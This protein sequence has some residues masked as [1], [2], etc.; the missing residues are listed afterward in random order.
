MCIVLNS[1]GSGSVR[2]V[3]STVKKVPKNMCL[4]EQRIVNSNVQELQYY[5]Y[6]CIWFIYTF[7][8]VNIA[9]RN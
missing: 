7:F 3:V 4:V 8:V 1:P 6:V 9:G 2:I 5:N